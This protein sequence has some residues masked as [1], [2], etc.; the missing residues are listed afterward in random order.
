MKQSAS[1]FPVESNDNQREL[2][3]S[4]IEELQQV[5]NSKLIATPNT[6]MNQTTG[7]SVRRKHLSFIPLNSK[8]E[9]KNMQCFAFDF[10][11]TLQHNSSADKNKTNQTSNAFREHEQKL[12]TQCHSEK[13]RNTMPKTTI[14]NP[15]N[16]EN[17]SHIPL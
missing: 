6:P 11:N 7:A 4:S 13:V 17:C 14:P 10:Q 1:L 9:G 3:H 5:P 2:I 15:Q 12:Q 16:F 8:I